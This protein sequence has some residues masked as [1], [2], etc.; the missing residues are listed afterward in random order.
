MKAK[1]LELGVKA[2]GGSPDDMKKL[3]D[4]E[5]TKWDKVIAQAGIEKQ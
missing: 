2:K 4:N 3:V 5:V 1:L